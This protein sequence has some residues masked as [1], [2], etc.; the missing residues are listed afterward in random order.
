MQG[1]LVPAAAIAAALVAASALAYPGGTPAYQTDVAPFC[2]SCHSSLSEDV[3]A[4]AGEL[5]VKQL[6]ENKHY[7]LIRA[8]KEGYAAL[9]ESERAT[10][11]RQLQALDAASKVVLEAPASVA[12]GAVFEVT[13]RVTG[14]AGPVVG[15]GLVDAAHRTLARP[16]PSA[17][18][19]VAAPPRVTGPD[20]KS[21]TE[22][23]AKRPEALGRNLSF[24][25]VAG[26]AS[27]ASKGE[28]SKASVSWTLRAPDAAGRHPLVAAY[29]Y[30]TEKG[31]PLG[32][33]TDPVRGKQVRGGFLG[34]S[35]RVVFSSPAAIEV[36]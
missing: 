2:S 15:V 18:F 33:T 10:L 36:K 27:D 26:I 22:W 31:S 4:G 25:N 34:A 3:F 8:G 5:A 23:L 14:G 35:G 12:P 7:A 11:I 21:Q 13:V 29:W 9:S 1:P 24:V 6:A 16:A 32:Y 17:G 28:W 30:G 19:A 20:G